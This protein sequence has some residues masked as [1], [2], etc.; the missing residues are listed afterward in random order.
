LLIAGNGGAQR[1]AWK[2]FSADG[3]EFTLVRAVRGG[4]GGGSRGPIIYPG[5]RRNNFLMNKPHY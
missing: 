1:A 2:E 3:W 4:G 5:L